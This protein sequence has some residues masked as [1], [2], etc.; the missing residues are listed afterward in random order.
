MPGTPKIILPDSLT[1]L[2][3]GLHIKAKHIIIEIHTILIP[4][5]FFIIALL[6]VYGRFSS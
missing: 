2:I 1:S 3:K 6:Q 4:F 5:R